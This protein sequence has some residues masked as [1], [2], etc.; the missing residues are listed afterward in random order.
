MSQNLSVFKN[1]KGFARNLL[2]N[3]LFSMAIVTK[4]LSLHKRVAPWQLLGVWGFTEA[5]HHLLSH[6]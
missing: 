5:L 4:T 2:G 1:P 6:F 3:S